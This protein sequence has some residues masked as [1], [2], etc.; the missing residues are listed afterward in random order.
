MGTAR[1]LFSLLFNILQDNPT[2]TS[3]MLSDES[4]TGVDVEVLRTYF[5]DYSVDICSPIITYRQRI[6]DCAATYQ[7]LII[8]GPRNYKKTYWV[9]MYILEDA[10]IGSYETWRAP[11]IYV[12]KNSDRAARN[13][14]NYVARTNGW[15]LGSIVG[16]EARSEKIVG[17]NTALVF[18]SASYLL[19]KLQREK[20]L[21][22]YSN[23][24]LDK[25]HVF[26]V[27]TD[28]LLMAI[29]QLM[30]TSDRSIQFRLIIIS[31]SPET[32]RLKEYFSFR[33]QSGTV[34]YTRPC[35]IR[36]DS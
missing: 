13:A 28:S 17:W 22:C 24:I 35:I 16:Y 14:A 21:S 2:H 20:T 1:T 18:C 10:I 7:A 12:C 11:M 9:S 23:I 3:R 6:I 5:S 33:T 26:N 19:E 25:A 30:G 31:D 8:I 32:S 27:G 15:I 4:S 36:I 34:Q 29:K